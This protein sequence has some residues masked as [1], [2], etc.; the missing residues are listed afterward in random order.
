MVQESAIRCLCG[1][2]AEAY[3]IDGIVRERLSCRQ[4]GLLWRGTMPSDEEAAQ[5]YRD[6][7]WQQFGVE[8]QGTARENLCRHVMDMILMNRPSHGTLVDVGCG[9]GALL[10]QGVDCG[11]RVIGFEL[12]KA[13]VNRA[14]SRGL[15]V[16]EQSWLPC[17]LDDDSADAVTFVNVLDHLINPFDALKEAWRVLRPGGQIYIRVPNGPLHD[18]LS[19]L[20][21]GCGLAHLTVMHLYGF[22]RRALSYHLT[23]LGFEAVEVRTSPPSQS[24]AYGV[25]GK[26][27]SCIRHWAKRLDQTV[28]S[29]MNRTGMDR[30]GWGLSVE[31]LAR[32]PLT[33]AKEQ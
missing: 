23:R 33:I 20:L 21:S 27:R 32:K 24:D 26:G 4:C 2:S 14:R 17:P 5:W 22:G 31:A 28:Y 30:L 7:Y 13:A 11:W 9:G 29:V 6:H 10:I 3:A 15:E 1:A 8:Q 18:Q 25:D 19:R 12:S 16:R